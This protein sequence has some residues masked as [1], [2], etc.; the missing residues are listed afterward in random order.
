MQT[1]AL[2]KI[3]AFTL[4]EMLIVLV[5]T[6]IVVGLAFGVLRLIS[7]QYTQVKLVYE[8]ENEI[9]LLRQMLTQDFKGTISLETSPGDLQLKIE[10]AQDT[11]VYVLE[12][13]VL[14][15]NNEKVMIGVDRLQAYRDGIIV[16]RGQIDGLL[17]KIG[18]A[19]RVKTIFVSKM[20]SAKESMF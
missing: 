15:R 18:E 7:Q 9:A 11:V 17:L 10:K 20:N 6:T 14:E 19:G 2:H 5:I 3:K 13:H 4:S 1:R 12:E 8:R 16:R